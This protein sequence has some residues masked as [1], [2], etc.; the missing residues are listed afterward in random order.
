M[1][2]FRDKWGGGDYKLQTNTKYT[3]LGDAAGFT[4]YQ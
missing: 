2:V 3:N 4:N 1:A